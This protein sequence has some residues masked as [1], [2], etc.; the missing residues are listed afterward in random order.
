M[1][2]SGLA[3]SDMRQ[4]QQGLMGPRLQKTTGYILVV[5]GRNVMLVWA[6]VA[7]RAMALHVRFAIGPVRIQAKAILASKEIAEAE[8]VDRLRC[9]LGDLI[10]RSGSLHICRHDKP[11]VDRT[12]TTEVGGYPG[13]SRLGVEGSKMRMHDLGGAATVIC[14]TVREQLH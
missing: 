3:K 14:G 2:K 12:A 11:L 4:R 10:H 9:W 7:Q 5:G 13:D 1:F 8:I 6:V